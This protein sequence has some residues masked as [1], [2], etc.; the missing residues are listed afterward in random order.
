MSIQFQG[1]SFYIWTISV[2]FY[3]DPVLRSLASLV[4]YNCNEFNVIIIFGWDVILL[5]KNGTNSI[6]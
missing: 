4:D 5:V 1:E 3:E 6:G 2:T